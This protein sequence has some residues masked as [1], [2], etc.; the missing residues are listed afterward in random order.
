MAT[1]R[2]SHSAGR[3]QDIHDIGGGKD[4]N[5]IHFRNLAAA[6]QGSISRHEVSSCEHRYPDL[7]P[8]I[9]VYSNMQYININTDTCQHVWSLKVQ[10]KKKQ[11]SHNFRRVDL[12]SLTPSSGS[13]AALIWTPRHPA[14]TAVQ[15]WSL[16][17][18]CMR[19]TAVEEEETEVV[20]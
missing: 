15:R 9:A 20:G 18:S 4:H 6:N 7:T 17:G 8:Y 5:G 10:R 3:F 14:D 16:F 2:P 11:V 13:R 19:P 1:C 12:R